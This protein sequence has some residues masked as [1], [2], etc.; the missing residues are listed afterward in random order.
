MN[1]KEGNIV[2]QMKDLLRKYEQEE[3]K[4]D[5]KPITKN[6]LKELITEMN[7]PKVILQH[8]KQIN[9]DQEI[10]MQIWKDSKTT[11]IICMIAIVFPLITIMITMFPNGLMIALVIA[12]V[13]L[14]YPV[15]ILMKMMNIQ[16]RAYK[17][18]GLKPIFFIR[19]M[20]MPYQQM[21]NKNQ[22][23][24]NFL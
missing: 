19:Q 17:K 10:A 22:Q 7:K 2:N 21:Q 6:D 14:I 1:E 24:E 13:G 23:G 4:Q 15:L 3:K 12:F 9:K 20:Q 18:Y 8:T 11:S 5:D 16:M